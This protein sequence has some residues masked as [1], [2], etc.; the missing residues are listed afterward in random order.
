MS[1]LPTIIK[2]AIGAPRPLA[3]LPAE[4]F[5]LIGSSYKFD[6]FPSGHVATI[7]WVITLIFLMY[8]Q[9]SL[10]ICVLVIATVVGVSRIACGVHWPTDVIG[11][12]ILGWIIS[13]GAYL[14][15]IERPLVI[16][17][18]FTSILQYLPVLVIMAPLCWYETA[19]EGTRTSY[20]GFSMAMFFVW[21]W[22]HLRYTN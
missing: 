7:F 14:I 11:G 20:I 6:A 4:E 1:F 21:L 9:T 16:K 3:V 2:A 5:I 18:V 12:A 8:R 19:Y 10:R 15:F 13:A 22:R 17:P